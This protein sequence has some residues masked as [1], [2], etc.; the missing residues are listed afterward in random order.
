VPHLLLPCPVL[1][2]CEAAT[3]PK[4]PDAKSNTANHGRTRQ[5]R[6]T[7]LAAS[8][9]CA[10]GFSGPPRGAIKR[11]VT[12]FS[13]YAQRG[14]NDGFKRIDDDDEVQCQPPRRQWDEG[15]IFGIASL[16]VF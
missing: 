14:Q 7:R 8:E 3:R 5:A 13:R 1:Q 9:I 16:D 10:P 15:I 11:R 4:S 2:Q 12:R 6:L